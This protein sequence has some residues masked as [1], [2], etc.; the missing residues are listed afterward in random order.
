MV[1]SDRKVVEA[2]LAG[3]SQ[4]IME[5]VLGA[6]SDWKKSPH[7]GVWRCNRSRA[8]FM[9]EQMIDQAHTKFDS[10]NGV[11][12][13]KHYETYSFT[14]NDRVLFRFKKADETGKTSNYPT[15]LALDFHKHENEY[16]F[17][18]PKVLRVEVAYVLNDLETEIADVIIVRREDNSILWKYSL[19]DVADG[20]IPLPVPPIPTRDSEG[21]SVRQLVKARTSDIK[22][23]KQRD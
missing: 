16:L 11:R 6:W 3:L 15:Q 4:Q 21:K 10:L 5:I 8:S 18:L 23:R 17:N 2:E 13:L 20:V 14:V 12:I 1:L 7:S 22:N 19:M 9:W